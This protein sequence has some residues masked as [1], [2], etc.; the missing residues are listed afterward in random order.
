LVVIIIESYFLSGFINYFIVFM[1]KLNFGKIRGRQLLLLALLTACILPLSIRTFAQ[2]TAGNKL[3]TIQ[4]KAVTLYQVF[5]TI[6][7]QTGY[8]LFYSNTL[9]NDKDE[10]EVDFVKAKLSTV[11]DYLLKNKEIDYQIKGYKILLSKK[12]TAQSIHPSSRKERPVSTKQDTGYVKGNVMQ[13]DGKPIAGV[14]IQFKNN[15][16]VGTVTDDQGFFILKAEPGQ[17]ITVSMVGMQEQEIQVP[18]STK[19]LKLTLLPKPDEMKDVV[20]VGY[21]KQSKITV[22]GAVSSV[23][24]ADMHTPVPNLENA[25]AGKVAGI[26][27]TQSSGEPGYDNANFT[28]RGIGTFTGI[29]NTAP[30]IIVDGV[31]RADINS[32][33]G[34]AFN[35]IDPE[36]IASITLLKDASATAMY[37]AQGANGVLIITTKRGIAGKPDISAKVETGITGFTKMPK[38]LNGIQYMELL[39][40]A[41]ENMGESPVYTQSQIDMTKSGL[42]P[43]LYPNVDWMQ[44]VYKDYAS[45]ANANVNISG[46]GQAVRYFV[47]GSFYNQNGPYNVKTLNGYNPNLNFKRYDFRSNIDVNITHT[48]LLQLNLDAMLVNLHFPGISAANIWNLT[49]TASPVIAPIEYPNGYW[50]GPSTYVQANPVSMVQNSGYHTEFHPTV[51]SVFTLTQNLDGITKGLA[52]YGRFSFDSYGEFDNQ[53]NGKPD[54]YYATGRDAN[55][56]LIYEQTQFGQQFLSYGQSSTGERTMYLEANINYDRNFG[57]HHIGGMVLYNMRNRIVSTAGD[58]ISSIPYRNLSVAGRLNYGYKNKYLLEFDA[59]YTGSENFA[60]GARFGLFP[61]VSGGWVISREDFFKPLKNTFTLFKI[62][63]SY[64]IVGNDQVG[65]GARFP[66]LT[67]TTGGGAYGFGLN[68]NGVSSITEGLLGVQDLTWERSHKTD[69]GLE[70]GLWSKLNFVGDYFVD[71]RTDILIQRQTV[72]S[73][74]GYGAVPNVFANM[75]EAKNQGFDAT[76]EYND[77]IGNVDLRVFGNVTYASNK[78]IF[79]D[80]PDRVN[81]YQKGT[82]HMWGEYTGYIAEGLFTSQEDIDN[83]PV[84]KFGTVAPGDIK[85]KD[86]NNDGQIDA[87]DW[88]YLGK[89]SFPKWMY[90]TGFSLN[91]HGFDISTLFQGIAGVGLMVNG[92]QIPAYMGAPGAGVIPFAGIGYPYNVMSIAEDRWTA[93]NPRQDAYYPR[94]TVATTSDNN[95]LNSSRWLKDGAFIR[96]KQLSLGYSIVADKIKKMGLNSLYVYISGTN[97]LTFSKFKLWDPELGSNGALYP[98]TRTGTLGIRI[99]F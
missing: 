82:G 4:R 48:T 29:A 31:Q 36:D 18:G 62:R 12:N 60:P 88:T 23:N 26:I 42:D 43:Y 30:L 98:I 5:Q 15:P 27:S 76:L 54:L 77:K 72:S 79:N 67:Q 24:M 28:I 90:G 91:Y 32:T 80:E 3:I 40:E 55:G 53:R 51:Q 84:Q 78:I 50:S 17:L 19:P 92:S 73:I 37:G 47:S 44:A 83:S 10:V 71:R 69:I 75:G 86:L 74:A 33:Y 39:N 95:Y 7:K 85:Y 22:T 57:D 45:M 93:D 65:A 8:V 96:L 46:G 58:V 68:G 1:R 6:R 99:K 87:G 14:S 16:G 94:L 66:Y 2:D 35:N 61:S 59:G 11:L 20:I 41:R 21:G 63:G 89:S 13:M 81:A 52:A 49:Y 97:L 34:G 70:I 64:G 25:L 9:L 56:N 38:M